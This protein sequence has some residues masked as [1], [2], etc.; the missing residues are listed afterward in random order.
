[1]FEGGEMIIRNEIEG[2]LVGVNYYDD[3][4][5]KSY[6]NSIKKNDDVDIN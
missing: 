5:E 3:C 6:I 2:G 4:G 1:M